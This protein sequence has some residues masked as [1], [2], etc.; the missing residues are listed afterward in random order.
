MI[1][2]ANRLGNPMLTS[3]ICRREHWDLPWFAPWA[4]FFSNPPAGIDVGP[5][6]VKYHRKIWE[7]VA[8]SQALDER[9]LLRPGA[10]GCGFAVGREPLTSLFARRGVDI[11]ATDLAADDA[12]A[13]GW[14]RTLQHADNMEA[15]HWPSIVDRDDFDNHVA[16][17]A[18][19]MRALEPKRLGSF[20]FIWSSCSFEHL[21]DLEAGIAFVLR[22][23][24]LLKVGGIAVHTTEFNLSSSEKTIS[25]GDD[26][27]YRLKD[28]EEIANRL[29]LLG[30]ALHV[31]DQNAGHAIEDIEYDYP[32]Y[33]ENNREHIKLELSG[34]IAT[35]CL[36]IIT[37]GRYPD[38]QPPISELVEK[39]AVA[40]PK[41]TLLEI[42]RGSKYWYLTWPIRVRWQA[43][44]RWMR[45]L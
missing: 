2:H 23:T 21:G 14:S 19:D 22:S 10:R 13:A 25:S 7:W 38:A 39:L 41:P 43:L 5:W 44:R 34:F 11:L 9:G 40:A 26:V 20:D 32:Q 16:F 33:Y 35:S 24:E 15:L 30:C 27:I 8:I 42:I 4:A 3:T 12:S 36:L 17:L 28:I 6:R 45:K 1:R 31:F 29:R 18:Q 37:K